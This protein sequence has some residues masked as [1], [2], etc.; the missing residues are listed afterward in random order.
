MPE[1]N[2][3]EPYSLD[4]AAGLPRMA[5]APTTPRQQLRYARILKTAA[6]FTQRQFDT[7]S[8]S[9]VAT[10]AHVPLGTLYRYFPSTAHLMLAVYRQQLRELGGGQAKSARL[11]DDVVP[12]RGGRHG[13]TGLLMEIFHLRVMQPAVEHCLTRSSDSWDGDIPELLREI[14]ALAESV[15]VAVNND[16]GRARIL[17]HTVSG[18]VQLVGCRRLSLFDAEKD[19]KNAC[20]LLGEPPQTK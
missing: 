4:L 12:Q 14:D 10:R 13:L 3:L 17:L 6:G 16:A 9:D 8:L 5:A 15:V 7:V 1:E 11:A 20:A 19:L 18:L 2:Y